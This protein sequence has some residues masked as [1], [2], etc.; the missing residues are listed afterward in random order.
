MMK[1]PKIQPDPA[2]A[3]MEERSQQTDLASIQKTGTENTDD[4]ARLYGSAA[5]MAGTSMKAP[6][7]GY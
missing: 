1:A 2:L 7:L 4:L 3:A 6:I 5:A